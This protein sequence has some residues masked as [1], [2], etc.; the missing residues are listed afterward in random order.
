MVSFDEKELN[1]LIKAQ[2]T[3]ERTD[4]SKNINEDMIYAAICLIKKLYIDNRI[5][6]T[7]YMN[8]VKDG[9]S[10]CKRDIGSEVNQRIYGELA[11]GYADTDDGIELR[12]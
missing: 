5:S 11:V 6:E 1:N 2:S 12:L 4:K 10:M 8:C 9:L 3:S 7:V